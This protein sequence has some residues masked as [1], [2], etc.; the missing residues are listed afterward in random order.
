MATNLPQ[1]TIDVLLERRLHLTREILAIDFL[2]GDV[3]DFDLEHIQPNGDSFASNLRI[4]PKNVNTAESN[5]TLVEKKRGMPAKKDDTTWKDYI[6]ETIIFMGGTAKVSE[7][8]DVIVLSNPKV[9]KDR[10]R[11]AAGDKLPELVKEGVL[12]REEAVRRKDGHTYRV[13]PEILDLF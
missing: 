10:V 4:V 2:L 11:G 8:A 6:L 3:K 7:L 9:T 12:I 5:N 1:S 13:K